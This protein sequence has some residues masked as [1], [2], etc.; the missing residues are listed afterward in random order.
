MLLD[1]GLRRLR[2]A[3]WWQNRLVLLATLVELFRDSLRVERV[4]EALAILRID[5]PELLLGFYARLEQA[6]WDADGGGAA[7][8]QRL[9][10][11]FSLA[12][13]RLLLTS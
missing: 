4:V 11:P 2:V 7:P 9:A 13:F 1:L 6:I 10:G 8:D 3:Q 5:S 12:Q